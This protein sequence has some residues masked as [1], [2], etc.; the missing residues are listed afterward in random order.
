MEFELGGLVECIVGLGVGA[1][2]NGFGVGSITAG[3]RLG[4]TT[5]IGVGVNAVGFIEVA[6]FDAGFEVGSS[7]LGFGVDVIVSCFTVGAN[8]VT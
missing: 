8:D 4:T 5:N 7:V 6:K 1:F 2:V 3:C